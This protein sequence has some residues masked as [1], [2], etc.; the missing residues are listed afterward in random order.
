MLK[1]LHEHP[2]ER[3][4]RYLDEIAVFLLDEF[5]SLVPTFTISRTLK[6]AGWSK[7]A[8]RRVASGRKA[9][10]RDYYLHNLSSFRSYH[11]VYVDESGCDKI[12]GFRRT[13]W[14]PLGTTPV[15]IARY[16]REQ[17]WQMLPAYTQDGILLSRVFQSTT[18]IAVFEYY[19]EQLLQH[20]GRWPAL[21]LVLVMDNASRRFVL[22]QA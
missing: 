16:Q 20:C 18:D 21:K 10:L 5:G 4:D 11:L 6:L 17:R 14:S 19:I 13:G 7:N 8:C 22:T 12:I 15:Q 3:P 9:N 2:V 1:A